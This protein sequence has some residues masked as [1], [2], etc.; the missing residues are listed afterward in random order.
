VK[1]SPDASL[2]SPSRWAARLAIKGAAAAAMLSLVAY[3]AIIAKEARSAPLLASLSAVRHGPHARVAPVPD[4]SE[5][6]WATVSAPAVEEP[7]DFLTP[8]EPVQVEP[9]PAVVA[10]D[11]S[12]SEPDPRPLRQPEIDPL[13]TDPNVR[14][15]NGRPVK[16]VRVITMV[17]T[18]YSPD[19]RSCGDSADGITA[20]L[21]S[22]ET[23]GFKL[24]AADPRVLAYG[25]MI[26]VPGYDTDRIVPVLDCGG[27]IKG[28]RLDVLFPTHEAARKWGVRK[29]PVT[30]WGYVDGKPAENP[31]RER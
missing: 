29:V 15:F 13:L 31:R 8:I 5:Y 10:D 12:A 6:S 18:A 21:H 1:I 17:V 14:W 9:G 25:S 3:S 16:P 2:L 20:T 23:N 22:V 24:V 26:T 19:A 28:K 7:F 11:E 4:P 27:A 30:V